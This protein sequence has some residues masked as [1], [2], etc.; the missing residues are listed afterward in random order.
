MK[1][2]TINSILE[3]L[4]QEF[5]KLLGVKLNRMLLFGSYAR[6]EAKS[7]SDIDVLVILNDEFQYYEMLQNTIDV[8]TKLSLENDVVI[9]R[10]FMTKEKFEQDQTPFLLNIRREAVAI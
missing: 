10:F 4:Q 8:V 1:S 5:T 9:S 3:E 2:K 6:G 7:D